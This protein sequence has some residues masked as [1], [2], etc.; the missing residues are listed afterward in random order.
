MIHSFVLFILFF[1][2]FF[3]NFFFVKNGKT[4]LHYA[5]AERGFEQ[6]VKIL[7]EHGSNVQFQDQVLIFL[8][9]DF[10]FYFVFS[11]F[12]YLLLLWFIVCFMLIV[13]GC[14]VI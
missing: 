4:A 14:C 11:H 8:F 12:F 10:S 7:V 9:F 5:F 6:I 1:Y 3:H 2:S 13:N